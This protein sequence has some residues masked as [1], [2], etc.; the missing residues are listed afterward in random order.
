MFLG[1]SGKSAQKYLPKE[2]K[3]PAKPK[4]KLMGTKERTYK[5]KR[6]AA[7]LDMGVISEYRLG[8]E[9]TQPRGRRSQERAST[10]QKG[11]EQKGRT[12][13]VDS[14]YKKGVAWSKNGNTQGGKKKSA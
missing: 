7:Y 10:R 8:P 4:E 3:W 13:H 12:G 9:D 1:L 14:R 11:R 2:K 5:K 6:R